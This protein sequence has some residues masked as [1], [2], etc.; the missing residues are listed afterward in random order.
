MWRRCHLKI[1]RKPHLTSPNMMH[2][3]RLRTLI[4]ILDSFMNTKTVPVHHQLEDLKNLSLWSASHHQPCKMWQRDASSCKLYL[5]HFELSDMMHKTS[6]STITISETEGFHRPQILAGY[7]LCL[8]SSTVSS[9]WRVSTVFSRCPSSILQA[10]YPSDTWP[11]LHIHNSA[12]PHWGS[13]ICCTDSATGRKQNTCSAYFQARQT[14][15]KA[16]DK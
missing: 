1:H 16:S 9:S 10:T 7:F 11:P 2:Q 3:V 15:A 14:T 8:I 13:G 4:I 5:S 12:R 6:S